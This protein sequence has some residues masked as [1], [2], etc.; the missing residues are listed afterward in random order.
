[1]MPV[2]RLDGG[3]DGCLVARAMVRGP[4]RH[5]RAGRRRPSGVENR[6][7]PFRAVRGYGEKEAQQA[8]D[9]DVATD[10]H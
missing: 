4:R 10:F 1:M 9:D 6:R 7:L 3:A 8:G 5:G 2:S